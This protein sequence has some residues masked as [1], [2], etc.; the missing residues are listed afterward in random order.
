M[1]EEFQIIGTDADLEKINQF[2]EETE[3]YKQEC[4]TS[5]K[6]K[7]NVEELTKQVSNLKLELNQMRIEKEEL[8]DYFDVTLEDLK[9]EFIK[10]PTNSSKVQPPRPPTLMKPLPIKLF[11]PPVKKSMSSQTISTTPIFKKKTSTTQT[12]HSQ[13]IHSQPMPPKLNIISR[14]INKPASTVPNT[15]KESIYNMY[16]KTADICKCSD[17]LN[18]H[19]YADGYCHVHRYM[20]LNLV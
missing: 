1:S 14:D 20:R 4:L 6:Y 2:E 15:L 16:R 18:H 8:R 3:K 9:T 5:N 17:C 12:I 10:K 7:N 11:K 13:P 19:R